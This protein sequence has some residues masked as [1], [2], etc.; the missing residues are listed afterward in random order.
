VT[1]TR[2]HYAPLLFVR[3][4]G[5]LRLVG[6]ITRFDAPAS[7]LQGYTIEEVKSVAERL[8]ATRVLVRRTMPFRFGLL[9]WK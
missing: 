4:L 7:V 1:D 6:E 8:P 5:A 2:R 3:L 9:I